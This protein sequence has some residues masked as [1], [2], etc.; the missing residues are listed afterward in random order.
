MN[1]SKEKLLRE[2]ARTRN[3]HTGDELR[4]KAATDDYRTGFDLIWPTKSPT[5]KEQD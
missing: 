5:I 4:S 1:L 3:D 2:E